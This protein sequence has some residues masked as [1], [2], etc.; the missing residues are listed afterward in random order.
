VPGGNRRCGWAYRCASRFLNRSRNEA[1]S[2]PVTLSVDD[3][4]LTVAFDPEWL[5]ANPLTVADLQ[6]EQRL[7]AQAGYELRYD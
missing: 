5:R 6:R 2:P 7:L 4:T 3:R 1:Q